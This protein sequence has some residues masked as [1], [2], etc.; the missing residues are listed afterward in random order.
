MKVK[1]FLSLAI[2]GIKTILFKM[3]KPILGGI[4]LTDYCNLNCKRCAVNNINKIIYSYRDILEEM[5]NL[6]NEGIRI[7]LFYGGE[8]LIWEDH[9]KTIHD[10][11]KEAK[12]IGFLIVNIV[13]NGTIDLDIPY[14]DT[15]FLSLDGIKESH[16]FIRGNTFDTILHNVSKATSSNICVYMAVNNVNYK[17]I[18]PLCKLVKKTPNLKSISFNF[19]TPYKGTE[20]LCLTNHQKVK[21]V[22][23]IKSMIKEGYPVFN[24]YSALDHYLEDNWKRPC[25]Q[26]IVSENKRRFTC[27]RCIEVEGLCKKCGYLFAIEFSLLCR[28]NIRVIIDMIKTYLKY[29]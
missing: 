26:C 28:G 9:N 7:L 1:S 14:A 27:G 13:T 29:I 3:E 12:Q 19:H 11:I 4:I 5:N 22:N 2:F 18:E 8:T 23:S 6:Y 10:L 20:W 25:Y 24:L 21:A 16:N 15:I 17:D